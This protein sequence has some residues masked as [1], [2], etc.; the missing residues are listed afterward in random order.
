MGDVLL[1]EGKS[2]GDGLPDTGEGEVFKEWY[3][4]N[5]LRRSSL[6]SL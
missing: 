6:G 3:S 1:R 4:A 2:L 5:S